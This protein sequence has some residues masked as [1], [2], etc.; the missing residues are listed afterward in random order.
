MKY[1]Y[2]LI[3]VVFLSCA[4]RHIQTIPVNVYDLENGE[5]MHGEFY[6]AGMKGKAKIL[7][8]NGEI[9][10]G[11]YFTQMHGYTATGSSWGNIYQSG[12]IHGR[13]LSNTETKINI[14]PNSYVGTAILV[15]PDRDILECEYIVNRDNHGSGYCIDKANR[16]YKFMF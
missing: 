2:S 15:C 4:P 13:S 12:L 14:R 1:C 7:K 3:L 11:E 10:E 5:V 16:K 9:C 6:Y 8:S